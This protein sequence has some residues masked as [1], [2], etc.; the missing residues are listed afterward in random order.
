MAYHPNY[1]KNDTNAARADCKKRLKLIR[2]YINRGNLLDIGCS[3]GYYSFGMYDICKPVWGIDI[4]K[5][6]I[7]LC[8]KIQEENGTGVRFLN[9]EVEEYLGKHDHIR[10]NTILYMSTHHHLIAQKG[11][12]AAN[13]ILYKLS[14]KC[15]RMIFDMGQKNEN[16][17]QH[18]WWTLLPNNTDQEEWLRNY[19]CE[20]TIFNRIETIGFTNIHGV[21]RLLW[22]LDQ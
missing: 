3:G 8:K 9:Y 19:L 17:P 16:C 20:H 6:L 5:K 7:D 10:W 14:Q 21:R 1:F 4:D 22:K 13:T 2:Q 18:K 15:G 11:F 12:E